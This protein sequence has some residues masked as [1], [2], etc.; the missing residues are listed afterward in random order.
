M[1]LR[2]PLDTFARAQPFGTPPEG[3]LSA[4]GN[5]YST[6]SCTGTRSSLA[7][8]MNA[9]PFLLTDGQVGTLQL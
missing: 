8:S 5:M 4:D 9:R 1:R 3:I 6:G 7:P 2:V